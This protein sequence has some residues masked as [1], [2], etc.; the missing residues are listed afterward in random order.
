[1]GLPREVLKALKKFSS[2]I[3]KLQSRVIQEALDFYV[4]E[5]EIE[6]L[7]RLPRNLRLYIAIPALIVYCLMTG[8]YFYLGPQ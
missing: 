5:M 6:K 7:I 2:K 1:M 4:I 8:A 3:H